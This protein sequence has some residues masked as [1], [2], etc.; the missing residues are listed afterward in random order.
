ML[1]LGLWSVSSVTWLLEKELPAFKDF[2]L[3]SQIKLQYPNK[4]ENVVSRYLQLFL[5]GQSSEYY[6]SKRC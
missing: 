5:V 6:L 4:K 3:T 2:F 1:E